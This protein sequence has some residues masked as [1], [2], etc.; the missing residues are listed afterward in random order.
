MTEAETADIPFTGLQSRDEDMLCNSPQLK[1]IIVE[2]MKGNSDDSSKA[3]FTG[4]QVESPERFVV[5]CSEHQFA[6]AIPNETTYCGAKNATHFC[7]AF[8][9]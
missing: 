6:Y 3:L 8:A 2:H 4:L 5:V 1:G 9:L 7:Q